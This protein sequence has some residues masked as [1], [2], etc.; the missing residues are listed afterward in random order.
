M[1]CVMVSTDPVLCDAP[2]LQN[3]AECKHTMI[4]NEKRTLDTTQRLL[5]DFVLIFMY[6]YY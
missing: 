5:G 3:A 2:E 6:H 4:E 1:L